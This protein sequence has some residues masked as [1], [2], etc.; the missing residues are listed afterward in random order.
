MLDLK[1]LIQDCIAAAKPVLGKSWDSFKP[2]AQGEFKKFTESAHHLAK[3]KL[4]GAIGEEE[5]KERLAFQKKALENVMLAIK[6]IGKV[7]AQKA[8]NA[9]IDV[10]KNAVHQALK[11]ALPF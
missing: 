9:V 7:T 4:D 10:V 1:Q 11:I 5:L 2:F 3:L 8:I 6:G